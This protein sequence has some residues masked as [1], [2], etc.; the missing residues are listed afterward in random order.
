MRMDAPTG[1]LGAGHALPPAVS[2]R[3]SWISGGQP[4]TSYRGRR[5]K[6]AA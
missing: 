3:S 4:V 1:V 6:A 2:G 5:A